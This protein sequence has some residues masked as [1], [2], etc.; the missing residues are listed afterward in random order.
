MTHRVAQD[1]V[2]DLAVHSLP[3]PGAVAGP[4]PKA[5][6]RWKLLALVL[7]CSLPVV[8]AYFVFY[9]IKPQG[10]AAFGQLID[11][12]RPMPEAALRDTEGKATPLAALKGQWLLVKVDG[13]ACVASCQAGLL[14]T[15]QLRL[16]LG[17][18]MERVD[19]VWLIDDTQAPVPTLLRDVQ[20]DKAWVRFAQP[21]TIASWLPAADAD[22]RHQRLYVVDPMG[23]AMMYFPL[24]LDRVT[25]ARAKHDLEHLL[26]ASMAWDTPGRGS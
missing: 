2:L 12:V 7:A 10:Q 20:R 21:T 22:Q 18:G 24:P 16:M 19:W 5:A 14:L 4:V 3:T 15:R 6:G 26:R 1:E 8:V 9:V 25:A 17:Q 13:G 23:N 11:P